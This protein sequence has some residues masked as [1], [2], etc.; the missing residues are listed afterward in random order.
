[1]HANIVVR[2]QHI[3]SYGSDIGF[4]A[5][6][7]GYRVMVR[8]Y[9][10]G[11]YGEAWLRRLHAGYQHH[12]ATKQ[13]HLAEAERQRVEDE[14]QRLVEAQRSAVLERAKKMG[15]QVKESREG[16]SIRIMLVKRSY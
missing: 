4:L 9:L 15:Y 14:R 8:G 5:S 1:M 13:A 6:P 7:T 11:A 12:W 3:G 16:S 2:S 10:Q